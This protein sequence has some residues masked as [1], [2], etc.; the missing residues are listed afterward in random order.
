MKLYRIHYLE[1]FDGAWV[2]YA[3]TKNLA[4]AHRLGGGQVRPVR[5]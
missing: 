3:H 2:A 5:R 4:V 1:F